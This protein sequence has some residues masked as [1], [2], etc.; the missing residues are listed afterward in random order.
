MRTHEYESFRL[1]RPHAFLGRIWLFTFVILLTLLGFLFLP[2]QQTVKGTGTLTAYDP[3]ER[4]LSVSSPITG[5]ITQFHV[6][7]NSD[8]AKGAKLFSMRDLDPDLAARM[9]AMTASLRE[10]LKNLEAEREALR[11]NRG[12]LLR[13]RNITRAL[14]A[15]RQSQAKDALAA[16]GLKIEAS[17]QTVTMR[18]A[19]FERVQALYDSGIESRRRLEQE[20]TALAAALA[21]KGQLEL[22]RQIQEH[23]LQI[24]QQELKR[25]E[26]ETESRIRTLENSIRDTENRYSALERDLQRQLSDTARYATANVVAEKAGTVVRIFAQDKSRLIRQ[27]EAVLQFSPKVSHRALQ[28]KV[29]DFNMPL[30]QEGLPVRIL[31]YGWP[32]LHISGWPAIRYGTFSGVIEKIDPVAYEP[33]VYYAYVFEDPQEPW[34]SDSVLRLGTQATVWVALETVPMWYQLWRQMNGMPPRMLQPKRVSQ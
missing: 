26:T 30:I 5:I 15:K 34:P 6:G 11:A 4:L 29:S 16:I 7:E 1:V 27:G 10:Q 18:Q 25:Y 8:V 21:D 22:E 31:F 23:S 9:N 33:G 28:L 32:T 3:G 13:E 14:Y 17:Q 24:L 19:S 12:N 2:W 20:Q